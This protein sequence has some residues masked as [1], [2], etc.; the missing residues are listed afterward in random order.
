MYLLKLSIGALALL[1]IFSQSAKA[2][3][4]KKTASV[5]DADAD[6][7]SSLN[8]CTNSVTVFNSDN[9]TGNWAEETNAT[10]GWSITDE[11]LELVLEPP[12]KYVRLTNASD[13]GND[14]A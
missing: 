11:G 14:D 7:S 8:Q 5:A 4:A 13:N 3:P 6:T 2:A 9:G 12:Q 10:S 1:S